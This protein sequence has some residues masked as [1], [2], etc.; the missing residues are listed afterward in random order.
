MTGIVHHK[1][2]SVNL[3]EVSWENCCW[4]LAGRDIVAVGMLV[5][6]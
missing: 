1:I 4:S 6:C 2:K 5:M 3:S